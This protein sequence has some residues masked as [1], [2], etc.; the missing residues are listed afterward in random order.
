MCLMMSKLSLNSSMLVTINIISDEMEDSLTLC[1]L[2]SSFVIE[3]KSKHPARLVLPWCPFGR[4]GF[5]NCQKRKNNDLQ[6]KPQSELLYHCY[7]QEPIGL[8]TMN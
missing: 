3:T 2:F 5:F 7:H 6:E 1:C 4:K 8:V